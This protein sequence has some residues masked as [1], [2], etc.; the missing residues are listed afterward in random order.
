MQSEWAAE[1]SPTLP[2]GPILEL[3]AGAGQI[4]LAAA[5]MTG[6]ALVQIDSNPSACEHARANAS[7]AGLEGRVQVHCSDLADVP[8]AGASH[9]L[10]LADPPYLP[11]DL[12]RRHPE[13]PR[14]A[15]DGGPDGLAVTRACVSVIAAVLP[16]AGAALLQLFG[17]GQ[18]A[19]LATQLP[20]GLHVVEIRSHDPERAVALI[21]RTT[22]TEGNV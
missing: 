4:G 5:A 11:S 15:I 18:G 8:T 6:R 16:V 7:A 21:R 1:L 2:E 3:C 10:V 9:P 14:P 17:A 13:D 12:V 22:P 20:D 19:S